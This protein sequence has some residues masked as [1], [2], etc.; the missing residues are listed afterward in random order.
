MSLCAIFNHRTMPAWV[1][2]G[3]AGVTLCFVAWS[4][5]ASPA[6]D[7]LDDHEQ[8]IRQLEDEVNTQLATIN[9]KL[10]AIGNELSRLREEPPDP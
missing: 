4:F 10:E 2:A 8:R 1:S 5:A 3:F 9:T 6:D 7:R